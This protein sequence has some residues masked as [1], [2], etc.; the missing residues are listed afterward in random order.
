MK[1]KVIVE[2]VG[3]NHARLEMEDDCEVNGIGCLLEKL[4]RELSGGHAPDSS[5]TTINPA[6]QNRNGGTESASEE[7]MRALWAAAHNNGKDI[8]SVCREYGVDPRNISKQDCW[9]MTQDLNK[10][11]GYGKS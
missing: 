1:I 6:M 4:N 2:N 9:R 5:F 10:R 11:S 3:T 8:E 7:A